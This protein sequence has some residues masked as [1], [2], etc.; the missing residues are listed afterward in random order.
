MEDNDSFNLVSHAGFQRLEIIGTVLEFHS[1]SH[2]HVLTDHGGNRLVDG[3]AAQLDAGSQKS[4]QF[5]F[6]SGLIVDTIDYHRA[7]FLELVD[8][9]LGQFAF[10]IGP[11]VPHPLHQHLNGHEGNKTQRATEAGPG[12]GRRRGP[13]GT[14][15]NRGN[16]RLHRRDQYRFAARS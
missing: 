7:D 4:C 5:R 2:G 12:C 16:C 10:G 1:D 15:E 6:Q 11:P 8:Q 9:L 14:R 13:R 3:L